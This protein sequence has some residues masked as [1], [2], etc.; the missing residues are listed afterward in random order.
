MACK[1]QWKYAAGR[2]KCEKCGKYL[3]P[4]GKVTKTP[5]GREKRKGKR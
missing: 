3:Q 2:A 4:D 5:T 1:H